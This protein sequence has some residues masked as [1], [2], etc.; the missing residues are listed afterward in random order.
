MRE[1]QCDPQRA[2]RGVVRRAPG[3]DAVQ[4]LGEV[5]ALGVHEEGVFEVA[6]LPRVD[7]AGL[8]QRGEGA[9][10][11]GEAPHLVESSGEELPDAPAN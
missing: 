8:L 2:P 7:L 11:R 5:G 3:G 9:E 1:A 4:G 6:F 10:A